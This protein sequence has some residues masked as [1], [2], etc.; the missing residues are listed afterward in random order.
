MRRYDVDAVEVPLPMLGGGKGKVYVLETDRVPVVAGRKPPQP[1]VLHVGVGDCVKVALHNDTRG[2]PV[3]FHV[4]QL[5]FDPRTSG[6]VAA[7]YDPPQSVAPGRT[8][9]YT[10]YASPEVGQTTA[11]V[12][13]WGDVLHNPGLGLYGAVV[14][15][16]RGASYRDPATGR[17]LA[18]R[19]SWRADVVPASGPSYRDFSLFFQD[20]DEGIGN[21]H[22]PYTTSVEGVV[23][24]NYQTAPFATRL[25]KVPDPGR[26]YSLS[27]HGDPPTPRP[28]AYV[29]DRVRLHVLAPWSEQ[30]QVFSLEGHEWPVE[31][32]VRGT[33]LVSSVQVGGLEAI[34][35]EPAGGAGGRARLAGDY[36]YG[37]HRMPYLEAGLWGVFR[38]RP[39]CAVAG[40]LHRLPG[41]H[42]TCGRRHR[43]PAALGPAAGICA[44]VVGVTLAWRRRRERVA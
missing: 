38:V 35:I 19:S 36:L 43:G 15:G 20:Q 14:V 34:T 22:M 29:G 41:E 23:G 8:R 6:G 37:D 42:P 17:D 16:P 39:Q 18:G 44:M 7:G 24:L 12:R 13:D 3:S 25:T 40:S 10:Y 1:L 2:G 26:V 9:S 5:A 28:A 27:A 11:L 30:A 4:D 32:G 33:T 21:H 31:P